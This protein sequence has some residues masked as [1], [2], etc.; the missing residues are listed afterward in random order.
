MLSAVGNI[1]LV[2]EMH[3]FHDVQ[4]SAFLLHVSSCIHYE[5]RENEGAKFYGYN[6]YHVDLTNKLI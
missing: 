5:R 2:T 6:Y 4:F 3:T 1:T